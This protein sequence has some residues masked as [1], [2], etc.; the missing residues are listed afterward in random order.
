[1]R[2][3]ALTASLVVLLTTATSGE[4]YL[5]NPDGSGDFPTIQAAID[6]VGDGDIVQLGDGTFVGS[7]NRAMDYGGKAITVRSSSGDPAKCIIDC[8]HAARGFYFHNDEGSDSVVESVTIRNAFATPGWPCGLGAGVCCWYDCSP[9]VRR[10]IFHN[11]EADFGGGIFCYGSSNPHVVNCTFWSNSASSGGAVC[12]WF[13]SV[14]TFTNCTLFGNFTNEPWGHGGGMYI[15]DWS[16]ATLENTIIAYS[17]AGVG[18]YCQSSDSPLLSC[19]DIYG[20]A[21]GDWVGCIASQAGINGNFSDDPLFCDAANGDFTIDADSPC[22]SANNPACGLV[23]AWGVGCGQSATEETT[24]TTL[25]VLFRESPR[26]GA[27]N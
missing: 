25:K 11:N 3:A 12:C 4:T 2:C 9:T 15:R 14:P 17:P 6:A 5:V 27:A 26:A 22:A 8:G 18:I 19:S 1:M 21:G 23:G 13:N 20:N 16:P 10:C 24:W 7:G